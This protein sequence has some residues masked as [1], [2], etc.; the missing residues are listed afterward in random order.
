MTIV[1]EGTENTEETGTILEAMEDESNQ[2]SFLKSSV[3]QS[4]KM[5][6]SNKSMA[7]VSDDG[8]NSDDTET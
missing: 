8:N 5:M 1:S 2:N 4:S 7:E 3:I 6:S